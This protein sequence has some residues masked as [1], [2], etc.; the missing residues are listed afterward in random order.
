[1]QRT[2]ICARALGL[3]DRGGEIPFP[4]LPLF[5]LPKP[6]QQAVP[7]WGLGISLAFQGFNSLW[8]P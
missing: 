3:R 6:Q 1:M 5:W 7:R 4:I 2:G 8:C